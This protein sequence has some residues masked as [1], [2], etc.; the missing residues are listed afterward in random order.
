MKAT[1]KSGNRRTGRAKAQT[2][3]CDVCGGA[4]MIERRDYHFRE[5]GLPRVVLLGIDVLH[6]EQCGDG[7]PIIPRLNDLMHTLALAVI[8]QPARL[9]GAEVRFLRKYLGLSGAEFARLLSIDKTTLSKWEND[10]DQAGEQ[11]DRLIRAIVMLTSDEL[12]AR[13]PELVA[14]L[15]QARKAKLK[16]NINVPANAPRLTYQYV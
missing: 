15:R 6:C 10:A 7:G 8:N 11:S 14:R 16:T 4:A 1:T 12:Q 2:T 9:A 3:I 13:R 5:V